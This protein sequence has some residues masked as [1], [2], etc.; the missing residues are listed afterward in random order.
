MHKR[1]TAKEA[2]QRTTKIE[3]MDRK[4]DQ[5]AKKYAKTKQTKNVQKRMKETK[6]M[7]TRFNHGKPQVSFCT[8]INHKIKKLYGKFF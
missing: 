4:T 5:L 6:R 1:K 2:K 8:I 7:A 3:I